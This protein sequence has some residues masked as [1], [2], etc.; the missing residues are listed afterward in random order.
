MLTTSHLGRNSK[1]HSMLKSKTVLVTG[2][3]RGIGKAI[4]CRLASEGANVAL[5]ARSETELLEVSKEIKKNHGSSIHTVAD[6]TREDQIRDAVETVRKQYGGIDILINGAGTYGA[7]GLTWQTSLDDWKEAISTNLFGTLSCCNAV[8]P[9]MMKAGKGKII[10]LAG[11]GA[12]MPLPHLSSY[13]CSKVA[14]VRLSETLAQELKNS[15]IQV[16]T[17]SPGTVDTK[18]QDQIISAGQRAGIWFAMLK[19][20]RDSGQGSVPMDAVVE[21]VLRMLSSA[22]DNL[23]GRLISA[24]HDHWPEWDEKN[25]AA[26]M[27]TPEFTVCRMD[28]YTR[29]LFE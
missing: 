1:R 25:I 3:G 4:A 10:N 7:I 14:I 13:A 17:I 27:N 23:T 11:G 29:D 8:I 2:A 20:I 5:L 28:K 19:K 6:V 15:N 22:F 21:L 18:I 24:Q 9:I 16:N 12:T 26:I